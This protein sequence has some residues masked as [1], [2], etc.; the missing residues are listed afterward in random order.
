MQRKTKPIRQAERSWFH[1][2][3]S[4]I[5]SH[6]SPGSLQACV[7]MKHRSHELEE[8]MAPTKM[9]QH[10]T[11]LPSLRL[12]VSRVR[13]AFQVTETPRVSLGVLKSLSSRRVC[14]LRPSKAAGGGAGGSARRGRGKQMA[15]VRAILGWSSILGCLSVQS[16]RRLRV[17][18]A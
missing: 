17:Y 10:E 12:C 6:P 5:G 9:S 14:W 2:D 4:N 3:R 18:V 13:S 8:S 11:M 16:S 1:A 7:S 15:E